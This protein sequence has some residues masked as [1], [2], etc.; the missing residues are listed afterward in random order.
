[1]VIGAFAL[2]AWGRPRAT[3]DLDFMILADEFPRGLWKALNSAG[4]HT[5]QTWA[6][7]N[8]MLRGSQIRMR[9]GGI[10]VDI[11]N[12]RDEHDRYAFKNRRKKLFRRRYLW[13]PSP[14]DLILQKIKVGRPQD[15]GDAMG[16]LQRT[17]RTLDRRYVQRWARRLGLIA[18]LDHV[19]SSSG[20]GM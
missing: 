15:F 18:E 2:S 7:H 13:F 19:F 8:P 20:L 1:M 14:E 16:I 10:V 9:S 3:L 17:G 4:F 11:L 6:S 5:D 12:P